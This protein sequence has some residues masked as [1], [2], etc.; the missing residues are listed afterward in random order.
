MRIDLSPYPITK[1]GISKKIEISGMGDHYHQKRHYWLM[2]FTN[3]SDHIEI[4]VT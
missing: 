1:S 2:I 4:N 3:N